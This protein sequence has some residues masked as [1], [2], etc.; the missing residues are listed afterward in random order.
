MVQAPKQLNPQAA[1]FSHTE[2]GSLSGRFRRRDRGPI[3]LGN[4]ARAF[5]AMRGHL[6]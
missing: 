3:S 6:F 4:A 2:W 5:L 1:H